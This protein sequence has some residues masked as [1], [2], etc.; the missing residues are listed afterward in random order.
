MSAEPW[1]LGRLL[2]WTANYLKEK[3]ADSPRLD[4]EVLLGY[5]VGCPRIS[6][7]T[8]FEEVASNEVRQKYRELVRRRVEGCPVAY[9]VG[10]KEFYNLKFT[11]TPAVLIPRPETELLVLE[12]I[13]LAKPLAQPRIVDVGTGSGAIAVTL[14]RHLPHATITAIDISP[15]ALAVAQKNA[16]QH[17]LGS[18]IQFVQGDLLQPAA[19]QT[20]DLVVSNPPYIASDVIP[21]LAVT[22]RG[23][24]PH[25]A[26]DGGNRGLE[27]I[28]RLVQEARNVLAPGGHF[29]CEI[30]YDQGKSVLELVEQAGGYGAVTVMPDQAGLPRLLKAVRR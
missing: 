14:A 6:L 12:A 27:I 16:D 2:V 4:A 10:Y 22:V 20:F 29:L 13:R 17:Q 15:E 26:L 1:T 23:Y 28:E 3:Q 11:V 19:G 25:V 18:R 7:Y 24:E 5:V 8:R 30:G 9:L 21:Q